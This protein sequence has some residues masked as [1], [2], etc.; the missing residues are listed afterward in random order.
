M[1]IPFLSIIIPVY[2]AEKYIKNCYKSIINQEIENIEIIFIDD[3][4]TDKTLTEC[5][6]IQEQDNRVIIID[7]INE[8]VSAA[9]N[10][11]ISIAK[12]EYIHFIDADD[13]LANGFYQNI[14]IMIYS[15]DILIFQY[16]S[17]TAKESLSINTKEIEAYK[18]STINALSYLYTKPYHGFVWDKIIKR[19]YL[20][21]IHLKFKEDLHF[22]EDCLFCFDLF[23]QSTNIG[24]TNQPGYI[25]IIN[26][27]SSMFKYWRATDFDERY[28][29]TLDAFEYMEYHL[30]KYPAIL[31]AFYTNYINWCYR[32]FFEA[33]DK[34]YK[35]DSYYERIKN[36]LQ[37]K[38]IYTNSPKLRKKIFS[39]LY[40]SYFITQWHSIKKSIK[41]IIFNLSPRYK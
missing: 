19:E 39:T 41:K 5:K 32:I 24:I 16:L 31:P 7:S 28:I 29:L 14:S 21:S 3:G 23:R 2:N 33:K 1:N 20:E 37:E 15:Y 30:K 35:N 8:G 12:G 4:S 26:P 13:I 9:R 6:N 40:F 22:H 38:Q 36:T 27:D 34:K 17:A 10:K 18:I 25:H 11:G